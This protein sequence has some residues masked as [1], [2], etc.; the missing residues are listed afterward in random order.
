MVITAPLGCNELSLYTPH[1]PRSA[2][3]KG[4]RR[5]PYRPQGLTGD[6]AINGTVSST[7][8]GPGVAIKCVALLPY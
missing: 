8:T 2:S 7:T 6:Q 4:K 3:T 1:A 5:A